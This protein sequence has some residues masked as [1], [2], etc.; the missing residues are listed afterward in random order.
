ME[1]S[2]LP[3]IFSPF[4]L[5]GSEEFWDFL[6]NIP[7]EPA[8][9]EGFLSAVKRWCQIGKATTAWAEEADWEGEVGCWSW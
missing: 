9:V 5:L 3:F 8:A 4:S 1:L 2:F 7:W 6:E